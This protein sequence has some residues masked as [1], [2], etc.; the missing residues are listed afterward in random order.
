LIG[1]TGN[2][3]LRRARQRARPPRKVCPFCFEGDHIGGRNHIPHLTVEVCERHHA[4]LTE[5]RLAAGAEMHKQPNTIKS[6]E[7]A[8]RA[9]AVTGRAIEW[10]IG[11]L[12]DGVECCAEKLKFLVKD[13]Q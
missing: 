11:R 10:A 7:M 6:I 5:K 2:S 12:C 1:S 9:L 3:V 13:G 8:L 4:L